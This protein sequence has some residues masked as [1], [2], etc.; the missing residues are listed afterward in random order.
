MF[1]AKIAAIQYCVEEDKRRS[2]LNKAVVIFS[3]I[4]TLEMSRNWFMIALAL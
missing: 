1:H 4:E 3:D 2:D